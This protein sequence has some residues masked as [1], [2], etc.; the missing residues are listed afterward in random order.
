[1][2]TRLAFLALAIISLNAHAALHKWVDANGE[3]HYSDTVPPDVAGQTVRNMSGKGQENAPATYSSKS[4]AEREAEMKKAKQTKEEAAQKKAQQEADAETRK[5][6]CASARE[7]A[8]T[9][10][11]A[12]RIVT[13]D[14]NGERVY[15]DDEARA[16]RLE[17]A[18]KA[19]SANCD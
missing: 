6:N 2:K 3:V 1:M 14:Q 12:G 9:L 19:I 10:E 13:Y 17:E 5:R 18:R 15:L 7:N 8:R 4:V 16:Q 11:E